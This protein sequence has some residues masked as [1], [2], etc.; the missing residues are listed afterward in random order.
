VKKYQQYLSYLLVLLL[1]TSGLY[2]FPFVGIDLQII[3]YLKQG[4]FLVA[5]IAL[6]FVVLPQ[7]LFIQ[8]RK[9]FIG[10]AMIFSII[11]LNLCVRQEFY[12][13]YLHAITSVVFICFFVSYIAYADIDETNFTQLIFSGLFIFN[14]FM[15]SV[16]I[17]CILNIR[18]FLLLVG[19]GFNSGYVT[20]SFFLAQFVFLNYFKAISTDKSFIKP[21]FNS[22]VIL[23]I[24]VFSGGR[25]GVLI[26]L[27]LMLYFLP[28]FLKQRY[29]QLIAIVTLIL[30]ICLANQYS[31]VY[32]LMQSE[33]FDHTG[34]NLVN[35]DLSIFRRFSDLQTSGSVY[36]FLD[37]LSSHRLQILVRGMEALS[38]NDFVVGKG[39][40]RAGVV[41]GTSIWSIHNV[42]FK[43]LAE[44]GLVI[45]IPLTLIIALPFRLRGAHGSEVGHFKFYLGVALFVACLVPTY[46]FT[47]LASCL[48]F[49]LCYALVLRSEHVRMWRDASI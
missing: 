10:C 31:P 14:I 22:C 28:K 7:K 6:G 20:F 9:L 35:K 5:L 16:L 12:Q 48:L 17:G 36:I 46:L 42:F 26:T 23:T 3:R 30:L 27:I 25:L 13:S 2:A 8:N 34:E 24:Q 41:I 11:G 19:S 29:L 37:S 32:V 21:W 18:E 49:W 47:G 38:R 39:L 40:E 4:L 15:L 1:F 44:F 43:M 45:L 33:I